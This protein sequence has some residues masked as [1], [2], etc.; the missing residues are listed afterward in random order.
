MRLVGAVESV[1]AGTK[2]VRKRHGDCEESCEALLKFKKAVTGIP[3]AGWEDVAISVSLI[4]CGSEAH[5][6]VTNDRLH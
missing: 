2:V 5:A 6:T 4:G 1:A 3:A